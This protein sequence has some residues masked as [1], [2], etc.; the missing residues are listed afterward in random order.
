MRAA[1]SRAFGANQLANMKYTLS[2]GLIGGALE[3]T[4]WRTVR[5]LTLAVPLR[6]K[7]HASLPPEIL[8]RALAA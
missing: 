1:E 7:A 2:R 3:R 4:F 5:L 6:Q 8:G